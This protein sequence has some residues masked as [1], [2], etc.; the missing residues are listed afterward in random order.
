MEFIPIT[1]VAEEPLSIAARKPYG[2]FHETLDYIPAVTLRGAFAK[3]VMDAEC[4]RPQAQR[5]QCEYCSE[6]LKRACLFFQLF[7]NGDKLF[8]R[9]CYAVHP[10]DDGTT[11]TT[12]PKVLPKTAMSCKYYPGFCSG[13]DYYVSILKEAEKDEPPHGVLD[14]LIKQLL[15]DEIEKPTFVCRHEC[16]ICGASVEPFSGHYQTT[17]WQ[18]KVTEC[19]ACNLPNQPHRACTRTECLQM[20]FRTEARTHRMGRAAINRWRWTAEEGMLYAVEAI[21]EG[22]TFLGRVDIAPDCPEE[23]AEKGLSLFRKVKKIGGQ[24]TRGL[25][26]IRIAIQEDLRQSDA[27]SE[28]VRQ[29]IT[30]FN[31]AI[32][33]QRGGS[34]NGCYFTI[35]LQSDAI[36]R[37]RYGEPLLKLEGHFLR[38]CLRQSQSGLDETA[39]EQAQVKLVRAYTGACYRSGW[40]TGFSLPK[41]VEVATEKGSVFLFHVNSLDEAFCHFLTELEQSGIGEKREEGCGNLI[42]CDPFH[43]EVERR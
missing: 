7:G 5:G 33:T 42:I 8:F 27:T 14:I 37:G 9:D 20:H 24:A 15:Y 28:Q 21:N 18:R 26:G 36:L 19:H 6:N 30:D 12:V 41:E 35:G 13:Y 17:S 34:S 1:I 25:G 31:Q 40:S 16:P 3:I 10:F 22:T 11:Q 38:R 23:L 29:R 39:F 4:V 43:L 2:Q 32:E